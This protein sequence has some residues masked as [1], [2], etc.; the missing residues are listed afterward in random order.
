MQNL[1]SNDVIYQ[2]VIHQGYMLAT[3]DVFYI[4]GYIFLGLLV[5]IWFAKPPFTSSMKVAVD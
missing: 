4:S 3:N 1:P 2:E 5:L